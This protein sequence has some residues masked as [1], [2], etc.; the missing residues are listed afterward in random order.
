MCL[1]RYVHVY[2]YI[3]IHIYMYIYI[4]MSVRRYSLYNPVPCINGVGAIAFAGF[5]AAA[6]KATVGGLNHNIVTL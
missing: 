2:M 1:H 6:N 4:H 3:Y 5:G